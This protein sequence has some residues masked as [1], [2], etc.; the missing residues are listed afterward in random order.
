M[1]SREHKVAYN[2][3]MNFVYI[4]KRF[5]KYVRRIQKY[6]TEFLFS[7]DLNMKYNKMD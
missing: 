2:V 1:M 4:V 7:F 3:A 6:I 5:E